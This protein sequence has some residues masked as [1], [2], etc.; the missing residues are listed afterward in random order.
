MRFYTIFTFLPLAAAGS[1][2]H[3]NNHFA[4]LRRQDDQTPSCVTNCVANV[5]TGSCA[6]G[7]TTCFCTTDAVISDLS[8]CIAENCS[9]SDLNAAADYLTNLCLDAGVAEITGQDS[10]TA[11]PTTM[12]SYDPAETTLSSDREDAASDTISMTGMSTATS[13]ALDGSTS[14]SPVSPTAMVA[15][16]RASSLS[17]SKTV[18]SLSTSSATTHATSSSSKSATSATSSPTTSKT[19]A[20][21]SFGVS[22]ALLGAAMVFAGAVFGF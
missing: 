1:H 2:F 16:T 8:S 19:S 11:V 13:V 21:T 6:A 10:I 3:R 5:N 15:S 9:S 18:L 14:T 22:D 12:T 17:T 7:D 4:H 20:G